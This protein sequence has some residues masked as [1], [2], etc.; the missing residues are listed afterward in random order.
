MNIGRHSSPDDEIQQAASTWVIRLDRGLTAQ[1]QDEYSHWLAEDPRHGQAIAGLRAGWEELDRLAG[2]DA[3]ALS[4][5]DP[6]LLAPRRRWRER[7]PR[8]LVWLPT[9]VLAAAAAIAA[10]VY[11]RAPKTSLP[12]V[13]SHSPQAAIT[14]CERRVLE[15]GSVVD[16]NRGAAIAVNFSPTTRRVRLVRGE[17]NFRVAKNPA[18]PFVVDASGVL[19]QAVGTVFDVRAS[20]SAVEVVVTE[21]KVKVQHAS[22]SLAEAPLV[23]A[24]Q[25]AIVSLAGGAPRVTTLTSD[26]VATEL[27]WQ[28]RVLDFTDAPLGEI[29]AAFNAHNSVQL[30]IGN[31]DAA[32]VRL[33][34][35]FRSDNVEGFLRLMESDFGIR[36]EWRSKREIV[37]T[38]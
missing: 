23:V 7:Q 28:P 13:S 20:T 18:R 36:T 2:L 37:L 31:A 29:A 9:V 4:A 21:G 22:D 14:P 32:A 8:V 11:L 16:L 1:E 30:V 3:T 15:D 17:A 24:G 34:A 5:P 38:K 10:I 35:V 25:H 19:V 12:A 6:D 27:A 33:S 26:A